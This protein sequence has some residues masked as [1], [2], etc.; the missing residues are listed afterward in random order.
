MARES[1]TLYNSVGLYGRTPL[2]VWV[3]H[4]SEIFLT[5]WTFHHSLRDLIFCYLHE[6][7]GHYFRH[8]SKVHTAASKIILP[9]IYLDLEKIYLFIYFG[10]C[11]DFR[12]YSYFLKKFSMW[13][14][15]SKKMCIFSF[16]CFFKK[17][18][19]SNTKLLDHI[20]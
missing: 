8:P 10:Q 19:K 18:W 3:V 17:R 2:N 9:I 7:G 20:Y 6:G 15:P 1:C 11:S 14:I 4:I 5:D 12:Q 13:C 16:K